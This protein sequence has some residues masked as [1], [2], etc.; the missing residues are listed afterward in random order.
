MCSIGGMKY[1]FTIAT[2]RKINHIFGGEGRKQNLQLLECN[3]LVSFALTDLP[4]EKGK[5][6]HLCTSDQLLTFETS[7]FIECLYSRPWYC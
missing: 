7:Y 4:I 2:H 6:R 1:S 3:I 5:Q